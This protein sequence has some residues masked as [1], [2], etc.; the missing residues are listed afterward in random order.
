MYYCRIIT[1]FDSRYNTYP[2]KKVTVKSKQIRM[3]KDCV[4][5]ETCSGVFAQANF[6]YAP[7][8]KVDEYKVGNGVF[9]IRWL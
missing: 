9:K 2:L 3:T 8:A 6:P 5:D 1:L 4:S 7:A